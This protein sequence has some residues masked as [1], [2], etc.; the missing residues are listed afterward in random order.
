M[1]SG[2]PDDYVVAVLETQRPRRLEDA[3]V[4]IG[5]LEG[6]L[7]KITEE[8]DRLRRAYEQLKEHLELLRRRIF[9]AKAERVDVTQL[10]IEFAQTHARLDAMVRQLSEQAPPEP[11][12]GAAS[13]PADPPAKTRAKPTGRRN[14][15]DEDLPEERVEI[16]N[17][18]LDGHAPRIGFEESCKLRYRRG[19]FVR[20]VV[21][22][23]TYKTPAPT[24]SADK[25]MHELYTVPMPK[26]MF[27][28]GLLRR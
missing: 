16:L 10:E 6:A 12:T 27:P 21:A 3:L 4:R 28:R 5:V 2:H 18:A 9:V 1:D 23:A 24:D 11:A 13:T 8:R 15:A 25:P 20:L 22:R 17:P 26:E 19:G 14:L 7:V